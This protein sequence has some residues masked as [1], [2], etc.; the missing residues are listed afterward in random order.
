M[1]PEALVLIPGLMCDEAA[2]QAQLS[3]FGTRLPIQLP[4]MAQ[5]IR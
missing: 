1:K 2:W 5:R 3:K 4:T